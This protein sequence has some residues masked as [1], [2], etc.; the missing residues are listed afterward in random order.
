MT[1]VCNA[2]T[3]PSVFLQIM[4]FPELLILMISNGILTVDR[5]FKYL[6]YYQHT[7]TTEKSENSIKLFVA[8]KYLYKSKTTLINLYRFGQSG[9]FC[10]RPI[11][12][13][14]VFMRKMGV[15]PTRAKLTRA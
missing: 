8:D 5:W 1:K 6:G 11:K 12:S 10:L 4:M 14:V 2:S 9:F 3:M 15:E 13:S 7:F